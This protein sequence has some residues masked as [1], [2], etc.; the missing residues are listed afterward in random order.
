MTT[1][2]PTLKIGIM[3]AGAVG[4]FLGG[5]LLLRGQDVVLVARTRTKDELLEHGLTVAS[6]EA[7]PPRTVAASD[8]RV[9]TEARALADRHVVL[10]C[11]KS[12]QSAE[13]G[14]ELAAIIAKKTLVVSMQNGVRNAEVLREQLPEQRVLAGIVGFNVVAEGKGMF[15]Q[16]TTG[17]LYVEE[18]TQA[19]EL[20]SALDDAGLEIELARDIEGKQWT[21]LLMNLNNATSALT[22]VP[23]PRLVF[24]PA[25]RRIMAALVGEALAVMKRAGITPRRIGPLP[26]RAFPWILRLPTPLLALVARAQLRMDPE[27]RSSMWQDLV[28]GRSTEVDHLNGEI[29][30][31][32]EKHGMRAP[33]NE[34]I[35]ELVHDAERAAKGTPRIS[36]DALW[37]ALTSRS[38][39]APR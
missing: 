28:K 24:E 38:A 16:A 39:A 25:Y 35:V 20:V 23:T 3:G 17:P 8:V 1:T 10:V 29:V 2:P 11:V 13:V 5:R 6:M 33:F 12:A 15:R 26:A 21:K 37:S 36:A 18:A 31:L 30:R 4:C 32:A 9:S 7:G 34:R 27:A 19:R 14:A 22:D